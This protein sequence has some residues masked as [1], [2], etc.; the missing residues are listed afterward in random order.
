MPL[1]TLTPHGPRTRV[2]I[3]ANDDLVS[4]CSCEQGVAG[5]GQMDCPWCGC[6]WLFICNQ[7]HKAFTF[8][9]C[10]EVEEDIEAVARRR[11]WN[12]LERVPT[13]DELAEEIEWMEFAMADIEV[14]RE[15]VYFDG[16]V[17]DIESDGIEG[18]GVYAEHEL[19]F[20]PQVQAL[21]DPSVRE[22]ILEN[23]DY[24]RDRHIE[25]EDEDDTDGE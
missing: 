25:D 24:W 6:G 5:F 16:M 19:E 21:T 23:E 1:T 10:I 3:K 9:K 11:I 2:L 18:E 17:V 4:F 14:G 22:E 15:Y 7:C 12:S 8:A 13:E 20:V